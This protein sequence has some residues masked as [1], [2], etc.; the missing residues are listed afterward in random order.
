MR[1]DF[2]FLK[3]DRT[4]YVL[5]L[6]SFLAQHFGNCFKKEFAVHSFPAFVVV[7][8]VETDV[9]KVG[10]TEKCVAD[11]VDQNICVGMAY[12]AF[13]CARQFYPAKEKISSFFKLVNIKAEADTE[14]HLFVSYLF[15]HFSAILCVL[16]LCGLYS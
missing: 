16:R 1:I 8:E 4:I 6:P 5:D 14:F 15:L 13:S 2:W 12:G 9:A 10:S 3:T 11:G 7:R